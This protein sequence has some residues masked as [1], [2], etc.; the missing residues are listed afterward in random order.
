[1][2]E[3][4]LNQPKNIISKIVEN[5]IITHVAFVGCGAS[6]SE[7]YPA[8]YFLANNTNKLNVQLFTAN[9]FNY[10]TPAWL[11]EHTLVITCSLG[12]GTPETIAANT[13]AKKAGAP[14][15]TVTHVADSALTKEADYVIVH[16]FEKNYAAKIEKM[17]YVLALA[18]EILQ[19][20]EG[21]ELYQDVIDGLNAI[22]DLAEKSAQKCSGLTLRLITQVS[23]SMAHLSSLR[24]ESL[25]FSL[26]LKVQ[27]GQWTLVHLPLC[28]DSIP[29]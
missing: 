7:L 24:M 5:H 29:R 23:I 26:C 17:G 14:V 3:I 8:K 2:Y 1:M 10:D 11:G 16:G 21:T 12:G 15:V 18:A 27:Q 4:D 19:Q 13:T 9:E 20:T 22:Y 6:M 28:S 25:I